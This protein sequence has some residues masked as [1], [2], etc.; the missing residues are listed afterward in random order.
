MQKKSG[1]I[2]HAGDLQKDFWRLIVRT[3]IVTRRVE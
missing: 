1:K 3:P 2:P